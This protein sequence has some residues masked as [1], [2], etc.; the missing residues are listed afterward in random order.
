MSVTINVNNL[1]LCHKGSNGIT[2]ATIPDVCKTPTPS[3]PVPLPYPNIAF[4][5]DLVKGTT[6]V[7]ADGGNMC[8]KYG[9]N[10]CKST[11]DEPGNLGG[12]KSSTFIKEASWITYSF[13]VKYEGKGA[14]RLTDKM[15]HNHQNTV[16]M[17]GELQVPLVV[18]AEAKIVCKIICQCDKTPGKG[19][20]GAELKQACVSAALQ[21]LD[22]AAGNK[23]TIKPEINYNMTKKPPA[24]I[25]S[26][27][28]P[29]RGTGYLPHHTA[30]IPG[31]IPGTG[32]VRRPDVV[33]TKNPLLPP[34]QDNLKGV[35]EIKF[36]PDA[37][38]KGQKKAYE[39]IAG[40]N[41][42]VTELSPKK[43]NCKKKKKK[44]KKKRKPKRVRRPVKIDAL[45]VLLV[46]ALVVTALSPVPGDEVA[47]G[48]LGGARLARLGLAF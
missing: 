41:A 45:D 39:K 25:M 24:P 4:S 1:S 16:N 35:F 32:M 12:V 18:M 33:L 21:A 37:W 46:A 15:F 28:N 2:T 11:G 26:K 13:D 9:S 47:V 42:D 23:T 17:G 40:P 20:A 48:A 29:L 6:T 8:A 5:S 27:S 44:K 34:T 14:C 38:G 36:P 19:A 31:F 43:C 22:D 3:G 7:K 10:F 30:Q